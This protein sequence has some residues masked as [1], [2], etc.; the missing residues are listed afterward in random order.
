MTSTFRT[1]QSELQI[2]ARR[3]ADPNSDALLRSLAVLDLRLRAIEL[4]DAGHI[5]GH[6]VDPDNNQTA[7]VARC[8]L[9]PGHSGIHV[10]TVPPSMPENGT[11]ERSKE[12]N[13]A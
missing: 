7:A 8:P 3:I 11:H 4:A 5:C 1:A 13:D 2:L 9:P 6:L 12:L 10:N